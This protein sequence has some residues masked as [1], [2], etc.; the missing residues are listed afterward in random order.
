MK[1]FNKVYSVRVNVGQY[2]LLQTAVLNQILD[3]DN[4][5]LYVFDGIAKGDKWQK[6]TVEW[7]IISGEEKDGLTKPD[8][9]GW[10]A[11]MFAVSE[12][13]ANLLK[14]GL[15]GCCELLPV[16]LNG[17]TWFA[18]HIIDK[19][20]AIDE[21]LTVRNM[22]NGRPSRTRKFEK[23]VLKKE[24]IKARGLFHVNGVG[25]TTYCTDEEGG[26]YDTVQKKG[27]SG[28]VFKEANLSF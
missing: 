7:M 11:T 14:E 25:L 22:R 26:F 8:I 4:D 28:L 5:S 1:I 21:E 18:L 16:R 19:Q 17:E 9:A 20:D 24:G 13:V 3:K 12:S 27:F 2:L 10:G 23:L 15:K 6:P